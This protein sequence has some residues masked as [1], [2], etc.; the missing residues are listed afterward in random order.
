MALYGWVKKSLTFVGAPGSPRNKDKCF[1]AVVPVLGF[2]IS[3]VQSFR[4]L[5]PLRGVDESWRQDDK[6]APTQSGAIQACLEERTPETLS[7]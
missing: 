4:F 1:L 2:C 5:V 7:E 3:T 6:G